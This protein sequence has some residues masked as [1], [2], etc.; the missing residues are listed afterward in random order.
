M[1][2]I[3]EIDPQSKKEVNEFV[4]L[5]FKIYKDVKEW[6]PPIIADI[7]T[8]LNKNKHPFYEHSDADFFVVYDGG[9]IIG[10][11]ACLENKRFNQY[12]GKK[13]A[14][15]YLFDCVDDQSVAELLFS[16]A[17][18]WA[19]D[20]DLD[21][22][23]GPKGFS[24]F[25]GYGFLIEGFDKRQ[26]M[27]M[28]NY[29]LP[30]YPKFVEAFGFTKVVDWVSSYI[31]IP[32]FKMPEKIK[33]IAKRVEEKGNFKVLRFS[34]KRELKKWAWR[35]GQAYNKTFVNNWEYYPLTDNEIKF[36]L[37]DIMVVAVPELFKVITYKDEAVGFLF[38][39][40]D[41]SAALQKYRG[42]LSPIALVNYLRELKKTNWISFNG[43]GVLPEFQGRGGNALMFNEIYKTANA[44]E[45]EHGEL[46][47]IAET[48]TQMR[49]DLINLGV[50]SHK[51]HRIYSKKI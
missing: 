26:M 10:R 32:D 9:E 28:M 19:H 46:T 5:P 44:F 48:A 13:H 6:V 49:K 41:I 31:R 8:K 2:T 29:N 18:E 21:V 50:K 20:R 17:E 47:Q 27:T 12:H 22:L 45:F 51:N 14:S 15:F 16:R 7:K 43:V 1:K 36:V 11:I 33:M 3:R 37:D 34:S 38:A 35:I 39:F 4:E 30:N 24:S 42:Q 23:I 40:P 25:D